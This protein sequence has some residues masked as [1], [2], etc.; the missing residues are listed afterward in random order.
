MDIT[1]IQTLIGTV[2]FPIACCVVM[3][4]QNSKLQ[5][6][7]QTLTV[8]LQKIDDRL[9]ELETAVNINDKRD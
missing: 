5:E 9:S 4:Y 2:G 1:S 3:F 7:L 6:T 8:T